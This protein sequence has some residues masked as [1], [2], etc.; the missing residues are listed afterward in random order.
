MPEMLALSRRCPW[1][2]QMTEQSFGT[3][4]TK[5]R[6]CAA[7]SHCWYSAENELAGQPF[8]LSAWEEEAI[9][10]FLP[11]PGRRIGWDMEPLPA[12]SL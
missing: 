4:R 9:H 12:I 5:W 1:S 3:A 11:G 8:A 6:W 2:N 7:S 10:Q